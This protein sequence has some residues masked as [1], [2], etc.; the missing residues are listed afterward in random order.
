V[1]D[2]P[3]P[4]GLGLVSA[5]GYYRADESTLIEALGSQRLALG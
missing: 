1:L 2:G 3:E 5:A 4:T